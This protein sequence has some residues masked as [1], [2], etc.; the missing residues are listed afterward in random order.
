[1][2]K[3]MSIMLLISFL[4][5]GSVFGFNAFKQKM[6]AEYLGSMPVPAVPVTSMIVEKSIWTPTID[7]IGFIEPTRGVTV[8][9]SESGLVA[10]ILFESGQNV[11]QG[12][13]LIQ[14]DQTVELANLESA[15][16]RLEATKNSLNRLRDLNK[17]SLASRAQLDEAEADYKVLQS[18]IES[19][20]ASIKRREVRAPFSGIMGIRQVQLGQYLQAGTEVARLENI[21]VMRLRFSISERDFAR[22]HV[23]M[24]VT[25]SVEAYPDRKFNGDISAIEPAIEYNSGLVQIQSSIPNSDQLLR[26]GM[27]AQTSIGL[28]PIP[29][30]VVVP[31][32]AINFTLY[33]ESV[34]VI[35]PETPEEGE[36]RQVAKQVTIKVQERRGNQALVTAGIQAGDRIVTSGQ[37][38]L[39]NGSVVRLVESDLLTPPD[40]LPRN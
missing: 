24:P 37:L 4:L 23:G 7:S 8:S 13:L 29:D 9:T 35:L 5:F 40:Q 11:Q 19:Y 33:G 2:K 25:V 38:K 34:Y 12:D 14:L 3:W 22:I 20:Q 10:K 32:G 28:A 36:A 21:D 26:S 16:A 39:S 1:M 31:Q 15:T 27:Y 18:Q 6:I 30:Q 17:N